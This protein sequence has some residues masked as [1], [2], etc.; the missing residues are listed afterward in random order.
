[1]LGRSNARN[2]GTR[3]HTAARA[4]AIWCATRSRPM[5]EARTAHGASRGPRTT[6][7]GGKHATLPGRAGRA[8]RAWSAAASPTKSALRPPPAASSC[9]R[10]RARRVVSA[11]LRAVLGAAWAR[12]GFGAAHRCRRCGRRKWR[13]SREPQHAARATAAAAAAATTTAASLLQAAS[14]ASTRS[15]E[16]SLEWILSF[17]ESCARG[18][19]AQGAGMQSRGRV[20]ERGGLDADCGQTRLPDQGTG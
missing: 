3:Q 19:A 9:L 1:M 16:S 6:G 2:S 15:S 10:K 12:R 13:A 4:G 18:C 20:V 5:R 7:G 11:S 17:K 8:V 14:R